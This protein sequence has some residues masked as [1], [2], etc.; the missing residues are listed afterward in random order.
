MKKFNQLL[1]KKK[2]L[3]I[4]GCIYDDESPSIPLRLG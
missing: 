3:K 2:K 4:L 1:K